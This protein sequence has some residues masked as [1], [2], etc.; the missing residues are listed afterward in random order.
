MFLTAGSDST[1]MQAM[2]WICVFKGMKKEE[3]E[4]EVEAEEE[5]EEEG[6]R[7]GGRKIP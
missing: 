5:K 7:R 6:E 1:E 2:K 4:G 3:M